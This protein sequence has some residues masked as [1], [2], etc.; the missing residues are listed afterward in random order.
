M[1]YVILKGITSLKLFVKKYEQ[2]NVNRI[3][4]NLFI[5][6]KKREGKIQFKPTLFEVKNGPMDG[7]LNNKNRL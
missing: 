6:K 1:T 4:S 7:I 2:L 3:Y 5:D